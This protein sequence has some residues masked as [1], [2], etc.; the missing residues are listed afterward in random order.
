MIICDVLRVDFPATSGTQESKVA[1]FMTL[2]FVGPINC[3]V[4]DPSTPGVSLGILGGLRD[5]TPTTALGE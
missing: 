3:G 2:S 4:S 1:I 5:G